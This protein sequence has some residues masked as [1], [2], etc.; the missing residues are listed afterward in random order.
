[1]WCQHDYPSVAPVR[2][3]PP[4][5]TRWWWDL[6]RRQR[7]QLDLGQ[8]RGHL[9]VPSS[10]SRHRGGD[11]AGGQV[12]AG[13]QPAVREVA[14][15]LDVD[16]IGMRLPQLGSDDRVQRIETVVPVR[17]LD[18]AYGHPG[19]RQCG[20]DRIVDRRVGAVDP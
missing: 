5:R 14:D 13:T 7:Q 10:P 15:P 6:Q 12:A 8:Q 20:I 3:P 11:V 17:Q 18:L 4:L 16:Q 2:E 19:P 1:M 9:A